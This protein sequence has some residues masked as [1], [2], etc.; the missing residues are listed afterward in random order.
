MEYSDIMEDP[1]QD[2]DEIG[3]LKNY[4]DVA[5]K[6][7]NDTNSGG[8]IATVERRVTDVNGLEI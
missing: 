6:L 7:D 4:I 5:V 2:V 1:L 3:S 8:N